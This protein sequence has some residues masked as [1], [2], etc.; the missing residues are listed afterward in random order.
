MK[1]R[2]VVTAEAGRYV[3]G[4]KSPGEGGDLFLT[5]SQAEHPLRLGH[6]ALPPAEVKPKGK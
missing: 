5:P 6:I 4:V 1:E 3:A 2:Y